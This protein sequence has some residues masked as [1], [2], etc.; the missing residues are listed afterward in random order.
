MRRPDLPIA[1][2][3]LG[4]VLGLA[5]GGCLDG[6]PGQC[7]SGPACTPNADC[8]AGECVARTCTEGLAD[9]LNNQVRDCQGGVL[10]PVLQDCGATG[11]VCELGSCVT[12]VVCMPFVQECAGAD[13]RKCRADGK[14]WTAQSCDDGKPCTTD[15]C[16]NLACQHALLPAGTPC[17]AASACAQNLCDGD[18]ECSAVPGTERLGLSTVAGLA[19][20]YRP[21]LAPSDGI[22]ALAATAQDPSRAVVVQLASDASVVWQVAPMEA[23]SLE[24]DA[25]PLAGGGLLVALRDMGTADIRPTHLFAVS[26][27][28]D[29][30]WTVDWP[31]PLGSQPM[32][33]LCA[34]PGGGWRGSVG[35]PYWFGK[36]FW[37]FQTDAQGQL[38]WQA[39][40]LDPK[41]PYNA[42]AYPQG[43]YQITAL[44]Q[45]EWLSVHRA[46]DKDHAMVYRMSPQN[47]VVEGVKIQTGL[48]GH[49]ARLASGNYI[50]WGMLTFVDHMAVQL[51]A[52][53]GAVLTNFEGDTMEDVHNGVVT[54]G[55]DVL[56][57]GSR[58]DFQLH[59]RLWRLTADGD[60][61]TM[62]EFD[63]AGMVSVVGQR[64]DGRV[65]L[66]IWGGYEAPRYGHVDAFGNTDCA[67][68]GPCFGKTAADCSDGDPCTL[69][70]CDAAHHGC[71]HTPRVGGSYCAGGAH[72]TDH[73]CW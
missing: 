41:S 5:G 55:D 59:P 48:W 39:S 16:A 21:S 37:L 50:G 61:P 62:V 73:H 24:V 36:G 70:L 4:L 20:L 38:T 67:S 34:M 54:K 9:C 33:A 31:Y 65:A 18:G 26:G 57:G 13:L 7:G 1:A 30:Q 17:A 53:D 45:G 28:G 52:P 3:L 23:P 15:T 35:E 68:S 71:Y 51:V 47:T 32:L 69:D 46:F 19:N 42:A 72:C 43:A 12:P 40:P 14:G 6:R 25:A 64:S 58:I 29:V 2:T 11:Q 56:V 66:V 22:W 63:G 44:E 49:V 27:T 10:G 8:V 60:V